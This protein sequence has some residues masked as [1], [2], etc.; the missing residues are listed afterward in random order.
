MNRIHLFLVFLVLTTGLRSQIIENELIG[1]WKVKAVV[2]KS[3]NPE[4]RGVMDGFIN[5]TFNF[6]EDYKFH[7]TT[8]SKAP[9]FQMMLRM[10]ED[11][12]WK[13]D[14]AKQLI[15]IGNKVDGYT[16]M[17]IY[18]KRINNEIQFALDES[19][20]VFEMEKID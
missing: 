17:G 11:A 14:E 13:F 7:L 1:Q 19:A 3:N 9:T 6:L 20:M 18:V 8:K 10:F 4:L 2:E 5:S 15:S 16:L 12:H